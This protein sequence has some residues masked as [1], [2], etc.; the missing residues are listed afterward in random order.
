[1]IGNHAPPPASAIRTKARKLVVGSADDA[2]RLDNYLGTVLGDVPRAM[3]YRII[4]SGEV[5][6]NGG[7]ARPNAR[8]S[9]GDIVRIPPLIPAAASSPHVSRR[10]VDELERAILHEDDRMLVLNKPAGLAVHGGSGLRF[11]LIDA[12]RQMRPAAERVNLVHRLD[13]DTSGCLLVAK[14]GG[15]LAT[16]HEALRGGRIAKGYVALL[17]G[18]LRPGTTIVTAPLES[19][20]DDAYER[21]SEIATEGEG[22]V[23]RTDFRIR[24]RYRGAT[25]AAIRLDT[26]RTH[27]IRAHARHIGHPVAGDER[28][29]D[30]GFN[31]TMRALGLKRMFL[32]AETLRIELARVIEVRAP[33]PPELETVLARLDD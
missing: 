32:H 13:R 9:A 27:Q 11:G 16:L 30:P 26:G 23:A 15:I 6:I 17:A 22:R 24:Q 29:G 20:R 25:L 10:L 7:R 21:R 33:L 8:V 4:R 3:I 28:Y 18:R 5:R 12:L 1:M 19:V 14:D 31:A 2:R